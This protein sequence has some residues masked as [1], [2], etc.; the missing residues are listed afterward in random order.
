ML[1]LLSRKMSQSFVRS[2]NR[3]ISVFP[4]LSLRWFMDWISIQMWSSKMPF[5]SETW[6]GGERERFGVSFV[7][8]RQAKK[9][10][11]WAGVCVCVC[12]S[13]I[14][15]VFGKRVWFVS[16]WRK[17]RLD[18]T[19]ARTNCGQP[20]QLTGITKA[21]RIVSVAEWW[22]QRPAYVPAAVEDK[23]VRTRDITGNKL[24]WLEMVVAF[25]CDRWLDV[26]LVVDNA[27]WSRTQNRW[28][29]MSNRFDRVGSF[30]S[31]SSLTNRS[32]I[33]VLGF[34]PT[35]FRS[36]FVWRMRSLCSLKLAKSSNWL[37]AWE[38]L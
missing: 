24:F 34:H 30:P 6:G 27:K 22:W 14:S 29:M 20:L 36:Q 4:S 33:F 11:K 9:K 10:R 32:R 1:D 38:L 15:S 21:V 18:L 28:N 13:D 17:Y 3:P 7:V 25:D 5:S 16:T 35:G 37:V 23:R 2:I 12:V 19:V 26:E 8:W 31:R